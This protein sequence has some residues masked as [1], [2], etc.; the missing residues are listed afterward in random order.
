MADVEVETEL[1]PDTGR[2][3]THPEGLAMLFPLRGARVRLI[4]L[5][6]DPGPGATAPTLA[7]IDALA[8]ERMAGKVRVTASHWLTYF[9]IHHAQVP[10][11]R[12]GRVLLA[13][14]AAHIHPP[15]S[16]Q[17][18][19][20]GIQDAVNLAWKLAL[21]STGRADESLLDSYHDER[22]P[23]GAARRRHQQARR[24]PRGRRARGTRARPRAAPDRAP[25]RRR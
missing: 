10:Q 19:N 2:M 13:G 14:D 4:F 9:E 16:G 22:H 18:M 5:V 7:Q 21:V 20:T 11:Y 23:V 3:F 15:A 25:A 1:A 17:G 8:R 6:D 24:P 12:H